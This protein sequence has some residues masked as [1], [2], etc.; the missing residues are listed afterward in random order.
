VDEYRDQKSVRWELGS[1]MYLGLTPI[2]HRTSIYN[3]TQTAKQEGVR[4]LPNAF[5][6]NDCNKCDSCN[7]LHEVPRNTCKTLYTD[8]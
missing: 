4:S 5:S 7:S 8:H 1:V 2:V 6:T 3:M